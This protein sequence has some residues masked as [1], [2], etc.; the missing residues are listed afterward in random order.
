MQEITESDDIKTVQIHLQQ[1][2]LQECRTAIPYFWYSSAKPAKPL[3]IYKDCTY[4]GNEM[5]TLHI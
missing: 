4:Y 1:V 5:L 3:T 2:G